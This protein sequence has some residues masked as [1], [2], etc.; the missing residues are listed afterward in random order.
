M[1]KELENEIKRL[2]PEIMEREYFIKA[3]TENTDW[4]K[5]NFEEEDLSEYLT[6]EDVLVA[7]RKTSKRPIKADTDVDE[8]III[9]K[10]KFGK[11]LHL[12]KP[13]VIE[14]LSNLI[15]KK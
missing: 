15:L 11:P 9:G 8:I 6:L 5:S 4:K 10:W 1:L 7:H 14:F 3:K 2:C 13:E 12:Q